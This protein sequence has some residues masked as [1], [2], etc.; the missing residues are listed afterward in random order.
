MKAYLFS[1][2]IYLFCFGTIWSHGQREIV[3]VLGSLQGSITEDPKAVDNTV[4]A[5]V[6]TNLVMVVALF[7]LGAEAQILRSRPSQAPEQEKILNLTA[8]F[9]IGKI[10]WLQY[11]TNNHWRVSLNYL[12]FSNSPAF[13]SYQDEKDTWARIGLSL[14]FDFPANDTQQRQYNFGVIYQ[15]L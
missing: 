9:G 7:N 11:V 1:T 6:R 12:P 14:S 4:F 10:L 3:G 2:I 8:G 5:G 13:F 15:I